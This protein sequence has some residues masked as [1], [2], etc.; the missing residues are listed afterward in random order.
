MAYRVIATSR[1]RLGLG[2]DEV[3]RTIAILS[4]LALAV[5][6]AIE[7]IGG[8]AP[9]PLCLDQRIAYYA[10][11][12]LGLLAFS[13]ASGRMQW[14][15]AILALLAAGFV[16]NTGL[17]VYHAGVEWGW[18]QGPTACTGIGSIATTPGDLLK[19]LAQTQIVRCDEAALRILGLSLAGYSAM[20]S[21]ALAGIA[22]RGVAK[23][24]GG[25]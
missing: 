25:L 9:C 1:S 13:L 4:A 12:P 8:I 2:F 6:L 19:S 21:A 23:G 14:S 7:H 11:V 18:W 10:A 22:L 17:G 3:G 24:R 16:I 5:A 15:R 20:L